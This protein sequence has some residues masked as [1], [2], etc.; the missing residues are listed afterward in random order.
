[1][2]TSISLYKQHYLNVCAKFEDVKVVEQT[3]YDIE[4]IFY[5]EYVVTKD[6]EKFG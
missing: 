2:K 3:D 5:H 6:L 1:M 4:D